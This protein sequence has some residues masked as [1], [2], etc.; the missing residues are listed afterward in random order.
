MTPW[1]PEK[2]FDPAAVRQA[3]RESGF[4][5]RSLSVTAKGAL[6][7]KAPAQTVGISL[8][9]PTTGQVLQLAPSER[10][11]HR[12]AWDSLTTYAAGDGTGKIVEVQG[13]VVEEPATGS[14]GWRL[15]VQRWAPTE[16]G[17]EVDMRIEGFACE[18]CAARAMRVLAATPGVVH[19]EASHEQG[20]LR[21][22]TT[23]STPDL[24]AL[25]AR[26]AELGFQM[27]HAHVHQQGDQPH[28]DEEENPTQ[29]R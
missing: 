24:D 22:W 18:R 4:T 14:A 21:V 12:Q 1:S 17:A 6:P 9:A 20:M 27:T 13:V 19:A 2:V 23:S 26:I 25:R 5:L 3:I 16:C 8:T 11:D 29:G 10:A 28:A 15:A 7:R